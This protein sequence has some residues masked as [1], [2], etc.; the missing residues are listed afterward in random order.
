[1]TF[2]PTGSVSQSG[3]AHVAMVDY[4]RFEKQLKIAWQQSLGHMYGK[5]MQDEAHKAM[6]RPNL[7]GM[8]VYATGK[9]K[10]PPR[11]IRFR[12]CRAQ[13]KAI[14]PR[15]PDNAPMGFRAFSGNRLPIWDVQPNFRV[16]MGFKARGDKN[17]PT[18]EQENGG[19]TIMD[20]LKRG[21]IPKYY[22][23]Q[24]VP[25]W[26]RENFKKE[27]EKHDDKYTG[28]DMSDG[29]ISYMK[30]KFG[31]EHKRNAKFT[32]HPTMGMSLERQKKKFNT[33]L[34]KYIKKNLAK[35]TEISIKRQ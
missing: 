35:I 33:T 32:H 34:A 12:K 8:G 3:G 16:E 4:K 14:I 9:K 13:G 5:N 22:N 21:A 7:P 26:K 24:N 29:F 20:T 19:I 27:W 2:Y 17:N 25:K 11:K 18:V 23:R 31:Y 1:M 10:G 6:G 15:V 28:F 30:E